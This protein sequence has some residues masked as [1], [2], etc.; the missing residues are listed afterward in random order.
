MRNAYKIL[1]RKPEEKRQLKR[2]KYR[3]KDNIEM[4][5]KEIRWKSLDLID[6]AEDRDQWQALVSTGMDVWVP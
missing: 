5:L 4:D 2:L 3:W 1:I 6:L